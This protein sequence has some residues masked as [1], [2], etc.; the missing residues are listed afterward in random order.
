MT[1]V[2]GATLRPS[3]EPLADLAGLL[4][5]RLSVPLRLVHVS[6]DPR[7]AIVLGTDEE[8]ILGGVRDDLARE[9]RRIGSVTG[10]TVH[11]HLAAGPVVEA[12]VSIAEWEVAEVLLIGTAPRPSLNPMGRRSERIAKRSRTPVLVARSPERLLRWLRGEDTL[13]V[14][15]GCDLGG[16]SRAARAFA[17]TLCKAGP[18]EVE[19][20]YVASPEEIHA[21]LGLDPP[22]GPALSEEA[23]AA[24][25]RELEGAAPAE[26]SASIRVL[27]AHGSADAHLVARADQGAFDLLVVGQRRRSAAERLWHDSV[28]RGVLRAA[29]TNVV[30]VP[31]PR[32]EPATSFTVPRVVLVGTDLGDAGSGALA[33]ALSLVPAAGTVHVA[34]VLPLAPSSVEARRAQEDAWYR[35]GRSTLDADPERRIERHVLEGDPAEQLCALAQRVGAEV[36]ITGVRRRGAVSRLLTG[37]VAHRLVDESPVPVLLV[38]LRES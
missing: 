18:C 31:A 26:E 29:P 1:V 2:F 14:L 6:E 34:H 16:A 10:A 21:R 35:L 20:T 5:H 17:A 36:L 28:A 30:S 38:P 15:V 9:A 25:L 32:P 11:P 12:L 4:A 7:A 22:D 24:V 23:E 19:V 27:A 37:S 3:G 8:S 13:R 33:Q